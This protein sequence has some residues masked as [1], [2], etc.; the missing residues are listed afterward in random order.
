MMDNTAIRTKIEGIHRGD[1]KQLEAIFSEEKRLLIE[2]PAGY[3]KTKTM[4]SKIAYLIASNQ[5]PYPKKILALTFSVNAA[6]KIKKD[7]VQNIPNLIS[8]HSSR[9][10]INDKILV[11]N[12]HGFSRRLLRRYGYTL[13]PTLSQIDTF[14]SVDDSDVRTLM[15]AFAG[16]GYDNAKALSDFNDAVKK[17]DS[18][19]IKDHYNEYNQIVLKELIALKAIPY[20]AIL[21]LACKLLQENAVIREFY[22]TLFNTILVDEFQDTNTLSYWLLDY[23]IA[24]KSM[25]ILL[26]DSLQR[27]YGFIGAIPGLLSFSETHFELKKVELSKNHRFASNEDMLLLDY[28]IRRNAEIP[29]NPKIKKNVRIDFTLLNDQAEEGNHVM[30]KAMQLA[31]SDHGSRVAILVKRRGKNIE[32]IIETFNQSG[33]D[34]F[35]GLFT[36]EDVNY[37]GFHKTCLFEFITLLRTRI[38][39]NKKLTNELV[40]SVK[41][42]VK[43]D[44]ILI[45]SLIELLQIFLTRIHTEFAFLSNEEKVNMIK[46]TFEHNGLKQYVEFVGSRII[47]STVHGA[48]GLEW[49]YVIIPDME[50]YSFPNWHGLCGVCNCSRNCDL[51]LKPDIEQKFLEELSVFYVAVTRAR[52]QVFFTAS[53]KQ[54]NNSDQLITRNISCFLKLPGIV[55]N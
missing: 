2:A 26:G 20:N 27:I 24:E 11:S 31:Q 29:S 45:D 52:R 1:D 48:K 5:I 50:A 3:G 49:E 15:E 38:L 34:F 16:L 14:Q 53:K 41:S 44:D 19:Y 18:N 25:V 43:T 23:L 42:K 30:A 12:Y 8:E 10:N 35:Y 55:I 9:V 36:D 4:V 40:A 28:N 32:K 46:D 6:Y 39:V 37:V 54:I 51:V 7:V 47:I 22:Q 17:I 21:S 33:V 13:H